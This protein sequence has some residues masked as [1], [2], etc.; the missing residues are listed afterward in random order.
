VTT[1]KSSTDTW[2]GRAA[3]LSSRDWHHEP[4]FWRHEPGQDWKKGNAMR[5]MNDKTGSVEVHRADGGF[6]FV[7]NDP[8]YI[9]ERD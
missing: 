2:N 1:A 6:A 3:T 4:C 5:V 8:A 7:P 9:K